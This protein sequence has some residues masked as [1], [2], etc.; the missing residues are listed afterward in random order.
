MTPLLLHLYWH[1]I[2]LGWLI[3][4]Q[5]FHHCMTIIMTW[6]L[7]AR[8]GMVLRPRLQ[9]NETCK[10]ACC[11]RCRV[12]I[13]VLVY[14]IF[15]MT[16]NWQWDRAERLLLSSK[17]SK[18]HCR[19]HGM[20]VCGI[21][22]TRST[23]PLWRVQFLCTR[24]GIASLYRWGYEKSTYHWDGNCSLT[25]YQIAVQCPASNSECLTLSFALDGKHNVC[26]VVTIKLINHYIN[27][28][29]H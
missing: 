28:I 29:F 9:G 27:L 22:W 15:W 23:A 17:I 3:E 8:V 19:I 12:V 25:L 21:G 13:P 5:P 16:A 2:L 24:T 18:N 20:L 10:Q 1:R 6:W 7:P 14:K 11:V 26:N 4:Q